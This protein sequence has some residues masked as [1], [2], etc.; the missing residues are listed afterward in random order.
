MVADA[1][2][3]DKA[4]FIKL[5]REGVWEKDCLTRDQTLRLGYNEIDFEKCLRGK[6][7][8]VK[9]DAVSQF[10]KKATFHFTQI[11][12]FYEEGKDTLWVTFYG[13]KLWWCFSDPKITF[14]ASDKSK[15]RPVIDT[16]SCTDKYGKELQETKL[17]GR[18]TSM[19]RFQGTICRVKEL[20]Y[21]LDKINGRT[22]AALNDAEQAY[23]AAVNKLLPLIQQ[24]TW[25]DFELLADLI[26]RQAGWRRLSELGKTQKSIDLDLWMPLTN[27]RVLVQIKSTAGLDQVESYKETYHRDMSGYSRFFFIVHTPNSSLDGY[28]E[29]D[30]D[31]TF[32]GP[33][34]LS[35]LVVDYGLTEWVMSKV[36]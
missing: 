33:L 7:E 10:G 13:G 14:V 18:L 17:S 29:T 21:L 28:E 19:R 25:K 24:L 6:W 11:R 4:L 15:I 3:A 5:G 8:E 12:Y 27:E 20:D 1:I 36:S 22:S 23:L 26:F 34:S 9:Q 2:K 35:R 32:I 16:W 31:F 30:E